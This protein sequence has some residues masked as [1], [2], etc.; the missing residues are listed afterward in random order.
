MRSRAALGLVVVFVL[1]GG[2]RAADALKVRIVQTNSA[3]DS[4]LLIDPAIDKVVGEIK[5]IEANHGA[6]AAPDGSRLYVTN[7]AE[8]TLDVV[9]AKTL[10]VVAHIPLG[11]HPNNLSISKDGRRVYVAIAQ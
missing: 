9:E 6:A 1:G 2:L 10:T 5:D 4:V 11:G 3:G 8:S 7:E